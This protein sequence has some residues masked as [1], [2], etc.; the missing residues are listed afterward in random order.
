[1]Y[2][3]VYCHICGQ[4]VCQSC[5]HTSCPDTPELDDEER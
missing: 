4:L 3:D 1:M 2:E 5:G